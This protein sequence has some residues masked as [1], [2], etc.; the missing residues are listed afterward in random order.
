MSGRCRRGGERRWLARTGRHSSGLGVTPLLAQ[1]LDRLEGSADRGI[2][3]AAPPGWEELT[4]RRR[5]ARRRQVSTCVTGGASRAESVRAGAR[6]V[7]RRRQSSRSTMPRPVLPPTL[8]ARAALGGGTVCRPG[9][10]PLTR[11]SVDGDRVV[12]TLYGIVSSPSRRRAF[13]ARCARRSRGG[14][15]ATAPPSSSAAAR[16]GGRGDRPEG[17]D[18]RGSRPRRRVDLAA[19]ASPRALARRRA[20]LRSAAYR[21]APAPAT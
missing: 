7:P 18:A 11:S 4:I 8:S 15:A 5:G 2:V 3:V 19:T 10:L 20:S 21:P 16:Q 13:V 9:A 1:S 14:E 12:E 6:W 17:D